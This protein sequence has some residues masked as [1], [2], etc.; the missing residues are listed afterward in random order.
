MNTN[1]EYNEDV[2]INVPVI[3]QNS[4]EMRQ[5]RGICINNGRV[6]ELPQSKEESDDGN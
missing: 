2:K 4:Y 6:N 1:D 3:L 5:G